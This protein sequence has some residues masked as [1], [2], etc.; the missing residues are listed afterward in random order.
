MTEFESTLDECLEALTK[1]RWDVDECLQ[2]HPAHAAALRPL[3]L[4]AT[5]TA[6]ACDVAPRPEFASAARERFLVASGQRLQE[7]MDVEPSPT[8]FA[9]ARMRFLMAA[10]RMKLGQGEQPQRRTWQMPMFRA[11][12]R[13]LAGGM[14]A[15]AIFMGA[16]AY[17]VASASAAL[18]G[19]WRYPIKLETERVRLALAFGDSAKRGVQLDIAEERV[20]E[21]ATLAKRGRIIGPGVLDRL[22]EQT[23]PLVDDASDGGWDPDD[24]ARLEAV[25]KKQQDV[26]AQAATQV[27]AAAQSQLLAALN[28]SKAGQAFSKDILFFADPARPPTLLSPSVPLTPTPEPTEAPATSTSSG[29][30]PSGATT[31]ADA[32]TEPVGPAGSAT[33]LVPSKEIVISD[34]PVET[35][36][37]VKLYSVV[38]GPVTFLAPGSSD[39]WRLDDAPVSGVPTLI[40]FANQDNT[41]RIIINTSNG[42][43]YWSF[44]PHGGGAQFDEVW[45]RISQADGTVLV[46]DRGVLRRAYGDAS[47]IPWYVLQSIALIPPAPTA[48]ATATS[49][50]TPA[51]TP[52]AGAATA[53]P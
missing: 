8:F 36:N 42:D 39:G 12:A 44:A 28:V 40:Q 37:S 49:P 48:T 6:Q 45:M 18:P 41:S 7:A 4:A 1:G 52:V 11:P 2:R 22:V 27:D 14:A 3:L 13:V 16:S 46:A 23:Q 19:D 32:A 17:T 21:I 38:A 26:L 25:T 50:A 43:M 33:V 5:M 30:S 47:D 35:R 29:A 15:V 31:P 34:A 10:Q 51:S 24:A 9:A 20:G 53:V